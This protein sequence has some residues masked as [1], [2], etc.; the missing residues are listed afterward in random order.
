[1]LS[2]QE[3]HF[4]FIAA[5]GVGMSALAKILA[6]KGCKVTGSDISDNKYVKMLKHTGVEINIG[7][8]SENI[9]PDMTVVVSSA[10]NEDN[11]ELKQ[12]RLLN[13]EIL[14]RSDMLRIISEEFSDSKDGIFFGFSGTHG[15]TTT[16][17]LCSY[18][19][20]QAG[21]NPSY[22]VGGFLQTGDNSKFGSDKIFVAELDESDGTIIK[23]RPDVNVINNLSFDHPDFYKNGMT[24]IINTFKKYLD[25][26]D[27][28]SIIIINSDN[29]GCISLAKLLPE[30][31]IR[32]FGLKDADYMAKNIVLN[33]FSSKFDIYKDGKYV[34][35]IE[36]SIPGKHNVY[37][38]LA[39]FAALDVKNFHPERLTQHFK[40]F[41][42][43]GRRFQTT[44]QFNGIRVIDDYAHHP[45]EIIT[46]LSSFAEYDKG[47]II[48]IFQPHRYTRFKSLWKDFLTAFD[49]VDKLIVT[50]VYSAG[51]KQIEGVNSQKFVEQISH[52]D[53]SYIRGDMRNVAEKVYSILREGDIVITLGAGTV[54]QIGE[55]LSDISKGK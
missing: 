1:M 16:S 10:V 53:C 24:D 39:V 6:E 51:E 25:G 40:M 33:D 37:N 48:A 22:A 52:K 3:K 4:Y 13:L 31:K 20:K 46:T 27:K 9:T 55:Q 8:K 44:A 14:H 28:S 45:E 41:A 36:L 34:T 18:L 19:L 11:P 30:R 49:R 23:Y 17:G 35:E 47:R 29:E 50:D 12:A 5:G 42:G 26:T 2:T 43:M 54:T 21:H 38:A 15:K 32:T 7:Q